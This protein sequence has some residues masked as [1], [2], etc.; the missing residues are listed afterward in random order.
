[1]EKWLRVMG[2]W[3]VN[4]SCGGWRGWRG[5]VLKWIQKR[6]Y[7]SDL[8]LRLRKIWDKQCRTFE[9]KWMAL[10]HWASVWTWWILC[11]IWLHPF[12][13]H[14]S[15]PSEGNLGIKVPKRRSQWP[16]G[17]RRGSAVARLL[18]LRV[19]IPPGAWMSVSCE[20]CVLS[21]IGLC[22]GPILLPEESYGVWCA[23][24]W[25]PNLNEAA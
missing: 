20:Y 5:V 16:R 13:V 4:R 21:G 25:S 12:F 14:L 23:Y 15:V 17:L 22:D 18:G 1:M 19:R 2:M 6:Y 24:V 3:Y 10:N 11:E 8:V 7:W 9:L